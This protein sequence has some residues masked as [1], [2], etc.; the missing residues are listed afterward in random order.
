ME[1]FSDYGHAIMSLALFGLI[2]LLL[3]PISA[4]RKS[5]DGVTAGDM[6]AADYSNASYRL[7]RAYMNAMEMSGMFAA[8]TVAAILAGASPFWVNLLASLFLIS[9]VVVAF[10]HIR[11]IGKENLGLRTMIYTFGWACCV[12]LGLM[13]VVAVF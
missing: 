7:S 6:P 13:A 1:Q 11:G 8:V 3:S 9:R 10:V 5:A 4:A 12:F 2:G